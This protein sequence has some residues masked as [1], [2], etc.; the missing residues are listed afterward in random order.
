MLNWDANVL[1]NA[2]YV[3]SSYFLK[4]YSKK[5]ILITTA[6][7]KIKVQT[8]SRGSFF[9]SFALGNEDILKIQTQDG[10][11]LK[12]NQKYPTRFTV[13][14]SS[15]LVISDIDETIL[16]SFT[17]DPLKRIGT[18][19]FKNVGQRKIIPFSQALYQHFL[20][21]K[22]CLF[23]VSKS[24]SNLFQIIS[25][26]IQKNK[27]A[28]G[29]IILTPF[30]NIWQLLTQKKDPNFKL[31][32]IQSILKNSESSQ[33]VL[34]GDDSQL[35]MDIYKQVAINHKD[36]IRGIYIRQSKNTRSEKQLNMW[37][38]LKST[39]VYCYYFKNTELFTEHV[40]N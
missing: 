9:H 7:K 1:G 21:N 32:Q 22:G 11:D 35:D 27:L 38:K 17:S 36:K 19:L 26:F 10:H 3:I 13:N 5:D 40:I 33:V 31:N 14:R 29:P 2:W 16:N 8:N 34:I 15:I 4:P 37:L 23:Y 39:G 12:F 30:I 24:E 18:T 25:G 6:S 28:N 20:Q